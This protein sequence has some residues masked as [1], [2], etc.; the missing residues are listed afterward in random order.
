MFIHSRRLK[1]T[2]FTVIVEWKT[3]IKISN[4]T[5]YTDAVRIM[6]LIQFILTNCGVSSTFCN[7]IK[8]DARTELGKILCTNLVPE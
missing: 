2:P 3:R 7:G 6:R 8:K 1:V 4:A 5:S